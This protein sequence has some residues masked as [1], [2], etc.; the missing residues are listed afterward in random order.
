[1][2]RRQEGKGNKSSAG[3]KLIPLLRWLRARAPAHAALVSAAHLKPLPRAH[4]QISIELWAWLLAM[5]EIAEAA[6]HTTFAAVE[7]AACFAEIG[8]RRELAV[9][10]SAGVPARVERVACFLRIVFVLEAG[11]D[12]A[13]QI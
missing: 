11:V 4:V 9:D 10:G 13:D 1:M 2:Q 12:V 7:A 8:D 3:T 6:T 5:N